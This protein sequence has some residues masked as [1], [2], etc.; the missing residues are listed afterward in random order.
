[1]FVRTLKLKNWRNFKAVDVRLQRR[2]FII[3]PN[4][5]GKSNFLDVFRF[6]RDV[7]STRGGGLQQ[8]VRMRGG[9]SKIRS[10]AARRDPEIMIDIELADEPEQEESSWRYL[11]G[12]KQETRGRRLTL[13]TRERVWRGAKPILNRPDELDREDSERR[14]QTSLEQ[15]NSNAEFRP[16]AEFF[17][18]TTYLHLVPQLL[19]NA[20]LSTARP[21]V[22]DPF[23]QGFLERVA[24]T[25]EK[26]RRARLTR[27]EKA[28]RVAVPQ[29][30]QLE[31]VRDDVTERPHLR[32]IYSHWRPN[33][34]RQREDQFSDGTLRLIG[35]L[36]SLQEGTSLL[37][38]EEPELSLNDGIVS[39]LAPLLHRMQKT[40]RS[41]KRQ[42][43]VTTHS[44]S[45]LSDP[46]IDGR[47]VVVLEPAKEG[48]RCVVAAD[49][50][51]V[52]ILLEAGLSVSEAV[53]NKTAPPDVEQLSWL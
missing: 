53:L 14:T 36:W 33:A 43:L 16:L 31:F 51:D 22:S 12:F 3:G 35:L 46:G 23:G 45:L 37:L 4:A 39:Q 50:K 26:T 41:R 7:S 44:H 2:Q 28:L 24:G 10:L 19:R 1:M 17:S 20:E 15:I 11:L 34:G 27:I 13:V 5:S 18:R 21:L 32:A 38:L 8:A 30:E 52:R 29:L 48:T 49:E 9:V 42:V 47:E 6:L 25:P 40:T